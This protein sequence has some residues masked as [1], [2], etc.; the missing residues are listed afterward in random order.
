MENNEGPP[1]LSFPQ[2]PCVWGAGARVGRRERA[3]LLGVLAEEV[4]RCPFHG[5][6]YAPVCSHQSHARQGH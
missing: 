4:P 1:R 2:P 5:D 6:P 3:L